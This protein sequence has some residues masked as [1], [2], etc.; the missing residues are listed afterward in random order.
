MPSILITGA[1]RGLGL[2]FCRQYGEQGWWRIF[3][4]CRDP[5]SATQLQALAKEWPHLTIHQLDVADFAQI[6]QLAEQLKHEPLS[7]LLSNAGIYGDK[8]DYDFSSLDYDTWQK[9]LRIN[10]LAPVKLAEAFMPNLLKTQQRL[11]VAVSSLMGSMADNGSGGSLIYRS[12]KAG[13][14]AVM[15]SLSID[16]MPQKVGVVI[17][18]PGWVKTDMGGDHAP[19]SPYDSILGMRRVIDGFTLAKS[20]HFINYKGE[21]LPW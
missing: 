4:C 7:I 8:S 18:H 1:N 15:K 11:I 16:L 21:E 19:T 17:L 6:D 5:E 14:N 9:T 20:G 12:S 10:T 13:L 2:E 3:A